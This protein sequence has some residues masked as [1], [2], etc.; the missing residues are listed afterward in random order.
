MPDPPSA[1]A[2]LAAVDKLLA[3]RP[4]RV[5]HDFSAAMRCL[6]AYRDTVIA[7]SRGAET[8]SYIERLGRL[9]AVISV[10]YSTHYPVGSPKWE[11][12]EQA[13]ADLASVV[14]CAPESPPG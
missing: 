14:T 9:N 2:A 8:P 11:K 6:T 3:D 12:L 13:R 5:T 1:A 4:D 7:R 10:V